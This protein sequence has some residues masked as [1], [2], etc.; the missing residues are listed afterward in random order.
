MPGLIDLMR[1]AGCTGVEFGSDAAQPGMLAGLGKNFT[2]EDLRRA[3][4]ICREA[5]IPFCHSLLLGGPGETLETVRETLD[6]PRADL[7][8]FTS[9]M[10]APKE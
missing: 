3:S 5:S 9:E 4:T 8:V 2:V 6:G 1:D 7:D 10:A